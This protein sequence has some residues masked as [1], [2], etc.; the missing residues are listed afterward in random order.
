MLYNYMKILSIFGKTESDDNYIH[1]F[2]NWDIM[3]TTSIIAKLAGTTRPTAQ[4][5]LEELEKLGL[6][7][8]AHTQKSI[9]LWKLKKHNNYQELLTEIF[10]KMTGEE[11][12]NKEIKHIWSS[13]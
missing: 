4:K 6:V 2:H 8:K 5:R 7:T 12:D 10:S 9:T 1:H 11:K 13:S 3:M